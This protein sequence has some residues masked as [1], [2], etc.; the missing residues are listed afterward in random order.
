MRKE[1]VI[2]HSKPRPVSMS[3]PAPKLPMKSKKPLTQVN[4]TLP[5]EAM[6]AKFKA[7]REAKALKEAEEA[8]RRVF[9]ARPAPSMVKKDPPVVRQTS[10]FDCLNS[11]C[12]RLLICCVRH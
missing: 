9:K 4:F 2:P 1:V 3:F 7:A 5:G 10:K 6:S 8:K 12:G 11:R